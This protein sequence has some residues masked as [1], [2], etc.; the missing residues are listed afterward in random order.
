[1]PALVDDCLP[2]YELTSADPDITTRLKED[3]DKRK[4]N[5]KEKQGRRKVVSMSAE[6]LD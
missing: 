5:R 3:Y 2:H 1:M 6:T 4:Q